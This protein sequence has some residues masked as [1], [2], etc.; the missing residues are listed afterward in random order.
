[1]HAYAELLCPS[2]IPWLDMQFGIHMFDLKSASFA[3]GQNQLLAPIDITFDQGCVHGLI[4]HNGSGKST[5]LK[6]LA[7]QHPAS[8][9]KVQ[10]DGRSLADWGDREFARQVAYLPQQLPP[11]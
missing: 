7:R 2:P 1:M 6:L 10:F 5:L 4:G 11:A 8:S 3:A 9:G